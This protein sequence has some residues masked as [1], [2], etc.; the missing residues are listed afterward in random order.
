MHRTATKKVRQDCPVQRSCTP[1]ASPHVSRQCLYART[2]GRRRGGSCNVL[3]V[4]DGGGES[5]EMVHEDLD[6][7]EEREFWG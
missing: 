2:P 3:A 1:S 5:T 7:G 6:V 4:V